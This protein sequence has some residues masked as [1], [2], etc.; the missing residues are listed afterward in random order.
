[1]TKA[2]LSAIRENTQKQSY[3]FVQNYFKK[4]LAY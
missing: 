1:M 4:L 3:V 2:D